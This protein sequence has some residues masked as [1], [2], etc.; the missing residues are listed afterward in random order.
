MSENLPAKPQ[1]QSITRQ[2]ET[3][4]APAED[5]SVLMVI[6]RTLKPRLVK[7]GLLIAAIKPTIQAI[8]WCLDFYG[9]M[10]TMGE[11]YATF[12]NPVFG[13]VNKVIDF[14][15]TGWGTIALMAVGFGLIAL[16]LYIQ[17][18]RAHR[19]PALARGGAEKELPENK[20]DVSVEERVFL[21]LSPAYIVGVFEREPISVAETMAE[22]WVGFWLKIPA[23]IGDY[24][25]H[26]DGTFS[27]LTFTVVDVWR[28]GSNEI[29]TK[30][31]WANRAT[32]RHAAIKTG[33][34]ITILGQISWVNKVRLELINCEI[35]YPDKAGG[36]LM[37]VRGAEKTLTPATAAPS[38]VLSENEK[39]ELIG[40]QLKKFRNG[41]LKL[42]VMF[43]DGEEVGEIRA[44][45]YV[46][47]LN[48][49]NYLRENLGEA[50]VEKFLSA[51]QSAYT[52]QQTDPSLSRLKADIFSR[53]RALGGIIDELEA[54]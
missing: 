30:M 52:S 7:L 2:A 15:N 31:I 9:N 54:P 24:Q 48:V 11:L 14:L 45:F 16:Q 8:Y 53:S 4:L 51:T 13:L 36:R 35:I 5:H 12:L 29:T 10:Q 18:R 20:E 40:I 6:R 28:D 39:R 22:Q 34:K 44:K 50:Y 43:E 47:Q 41:S 42:L 17:H 37:E 38:G 21:D 3:A 26:S 19:M 1:E 46:W 25:Q 33:D 27:P 23:Y 32:L 49:V